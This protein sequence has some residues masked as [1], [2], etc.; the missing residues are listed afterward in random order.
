MAYAP[1]GAKGLRVSETGTVNES[2]HGFDSIWAWRVVLDAGFLR[3]C[4]LQPHFLRRICLAVGS[5]PARSGQGVCHGGATRGKLPVKLG[6]VAKKSGKGDEA[7]IQHHTPSP[8]ME[9]AGEKEERPA[10]QQL[11]AGH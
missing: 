4:P 7:S 5:C 6:P 11:E 9:P 1:R 2:A 8:D 10:S 3:V